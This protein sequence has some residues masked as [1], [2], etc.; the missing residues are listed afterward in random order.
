MRKLSL[1]CV[2]FAGMAIHLKA[3]QIAWN[4][5]SLNMTPSGEMSLEWTNYPK[6]SF[7]L[8]VWCELSS[9]PYGYNWTLMPTGAIM[10]FTGTVYEARAGEIVNHQFAQSARPAFAIKDEDGEKPEPWTPIS[11]VEPGNRFLA[12]SLVD[13][14]SNEIFGWIELRIDGNS[15]GGNVSISGSAIDLDGGPM[16][17]GGG[18]WEGA[19]PEP[20]SGILLLLGG[21]LLALR[22]AR[23]T[24]K[25]IVL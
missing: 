10:E 2:M 22:R 3:A 17:V 9:S 4:V 8:N 21:A 6:G 16:I 5:V 7:W 11:G 1:V 24:V 14:Q 25:R 23:C 13:L 12:F 20:V 19:T 18:A 15:T